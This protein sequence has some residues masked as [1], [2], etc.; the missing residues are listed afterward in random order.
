VL[1][2]CKSEACEAPFHRDESVT[3]AELKTGAEDAWFW[4]VTQ[5]HEPVY[6]L[7]HRLL[8]DPLG[9]PDITQAVFLNAF[10][11][12]KGFESNSGLKTWLYRIALRETGRRRWWLWHTIRRPAAFSAAPNCESLEIVASEAAQGDSRISRREALLSELFDELPTEV[13]QALKELKLPYRAAVI[14][15][16]LEKLPCED[17]AE[18]TGVSLKKVKL[19]LA[20]G[21]GA[22]AKRLENCFRD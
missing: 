6:T 9:A 17:I 15:R 18:V 5:Y 3:V 20:R 21:R 1:A 13:E 14:L 2:R 8:D 10:R 4:L 12:I 16:D 11:E 22:L 19:R 7:I